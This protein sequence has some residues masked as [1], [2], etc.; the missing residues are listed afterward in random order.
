MDNQCFMQSVL[1]EKIKI[2]KESK[3]IKIKKNN[4]SN[5]F[6]IQT[7]AEKKDAQTDK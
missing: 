4:N 7:Y 1:C 6:K 5:A 3:N 2:R